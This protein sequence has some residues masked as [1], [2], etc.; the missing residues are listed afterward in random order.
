MKGDT[1]D[2][3]SKWRQMV[4]KRKV[5]AAHPGPMVG[6][7]S[8]EKPDSKPRPEAIVNKPAL[9]HICRKVSSADS[10]ASV[11]VIKLNEVE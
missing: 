7:T 4:R 2:Q 8:E 5:K 10:G 11:R 1:D 3:K 9:G 6:P